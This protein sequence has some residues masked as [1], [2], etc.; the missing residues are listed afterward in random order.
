MA[1]ESLSLMI[2]IIYINIINKNNIDVNDLFNI[3][4]QFCKH[5]CK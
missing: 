2:K 4:I 1:A 5:T 3:E